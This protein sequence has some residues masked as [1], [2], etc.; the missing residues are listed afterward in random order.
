MI[1]Y[2]KKIEAVLKGRPFKGPLFPRLR[3]A[4]SSD[5][6][7]EFKQR[8]KGSGRR[9]AMRVAP[10]QAPQHFLNF[11]PLP[12]GQGSLRPI[13]SLLTESWVSNCCLTW[14]K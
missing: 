2:G 7:T 1:K 14:A 10:V 6:A 11:F 13:F 3:P 8:C 9:R 4:R 12:H 5:R